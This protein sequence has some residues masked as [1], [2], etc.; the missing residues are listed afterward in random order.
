MPW[1]LAA[2]IGFLLIIVGM[3]I[4]GNRIAALREKAELDAMSP[5]D[6]AEH[7]R[8]LA[9]R[10]ANDVKVAKMRQAERNATWAHGKVN[11]QMVCPHCQ[12]RGKVR[13]K[14]IEKKAGISGGKATAALLTG[15]IS[16]LATGLS[17][18]EELTQAHCDNCSSTWAF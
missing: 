12:T 7:Q 18:K 16:V 6:R 17:R 5:A 13:V 8:A 4:Y 11:S 3:I 1:A 10:R 2:V 14:A 9:E 15:G